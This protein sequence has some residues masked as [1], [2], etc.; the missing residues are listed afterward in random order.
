MPLEPQIAQTE[1]VHLIVRGLVQGV[2]FRWF[3]QRRAA[4]LGLGGFVR[5]LPDGSVEIVAEGERASL[6]ALLDVVR[7]G[8]TAA[9]I[10][11]IDSQWGSPSGEFSRFEIRY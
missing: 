3:V 1:R 6:D 11:N 4:G 7:V 2:N 5:N 10:E 8:S 9:I